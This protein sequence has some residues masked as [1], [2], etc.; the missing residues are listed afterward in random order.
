MMLVSAPSPT[1]V[2]AVLDGWFPVLL[3]ER[4]GE[5][6]G[7]RDQAFTAARSASKG[8]DSAVA[9]LRSG[10]L[11]TVY[12]LL[13]ES[14]DGKSFGGIDFETGGAPRL[15]V[16]EQPMSGLVAIIDGVKL[17]TNDRAA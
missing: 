2:A 16:I 9:V 17:I 15:P 1:K 11:F 3:G 7:S 12:E 13:A 14:P 6:H 4:I 8:P 10:D 5:D